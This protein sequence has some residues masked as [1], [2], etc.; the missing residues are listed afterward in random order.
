MSKEIVLLSNGQ[1]YQENQ[2]TGEIEEVIITDK[3]KNELVKNFQPDVIYATVDHQDLQGNTESYGYLDSIRLDEGNNLVGVPTWNEQG[4]DI[5]DKKMYNRISIFF[6]YNADKEA[7]LVS[8]S[9]TNDPADVTQK[10]MALSYLTNRKKNAI[11]NICALSSSIMIGE[12]NKNKSEDPNNEDDSTKNNN[13]SLKMTPEE[14]KIQDDLKAE[15]EKLLGQI[16]ELEKKIEDMV[17][18]PPTQKKVDDVDEDINRDLSVT[19]PKEKPI[20]AFSMFLEST[21]LNENSTK[22]EIE[23][24]LQ[25]LVAD[26]G[27]ALSYKLGGAKKEEKP[28]QEPGVI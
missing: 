18:D 25:S 17:K 14:Q 19:T 3:V 23:S 20:T 12:D 1:I 11:N 22:E 21:G 10:P 27:V 2:K 7:E 6:R 26:K 4:Q 16:A 5:V 8:F 28:T 9:F 13:R 15:N 24:G